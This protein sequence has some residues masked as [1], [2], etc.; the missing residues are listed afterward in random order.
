MEKLAKFEPIARSNGEKV[1]ILYNFK[2]ENRKKEQ[3]LALSLICILFLY[4]E[5]YVCIL[6][7]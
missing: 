7:V 4:F 3:D 1:I 6:P 2:Q 5:C